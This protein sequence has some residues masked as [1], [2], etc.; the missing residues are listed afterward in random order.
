[1]IKEFSSPFSCQV[2]L[3]MIRAKETEGQNQTAPVADLSLTS[4]RPL[5]PQAMKPL[6][7][8]HQ[9]ARAQRYS[10]QPQ[11]LPLSLCF[12]P[13]SHQGSSA[14]GASR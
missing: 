2:W 12:P 7:S 9:K 10:L 6:I 4:T 13:A 1:M 14:A 5:I 3:D 8:R 11:T